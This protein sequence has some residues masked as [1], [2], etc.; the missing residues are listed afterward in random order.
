MEIDGSDQELLI[1]SSGGWPAWSPDGSQIA[2]F[3]RKDGNPEIYIADAD[4]TNQTRITFNYVD[5]WEPSWS[6]D[7]EWLLYNTG[8]LNNI[9][10]MNVDTRET[11]QLTNN[12]Y[13]EWLPVWRP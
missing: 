7:G 1:D 11:F 2:F 4:G 3:G 12:N 9:F 10:I 13:I 8:P 5:D 6:P